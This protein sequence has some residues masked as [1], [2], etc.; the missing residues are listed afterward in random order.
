MLYIGLHSEPAL[1]QAQ[2]KTVV[3][4]IDNATTLKPQHTWETDISP[5]VAAAQAGN[6][7]IR[8]AADK[9]ALEALQAQQVAEATRQVAAQVTHRTQAVSGSCGDP[10]SCIYFRESGNNPTKWNTSGCVGLGQ[11]CPA[12]KLMAIC[13][14]LDYA[15]EDAWFTNYMLGRYGSWEAAWVFWQRTD[16]R[17]YCGN[18]W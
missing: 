15:C 10:K 16:C 1:G 8:D 7:T 3:Q 11:A 2:A 12:S 4:Q 9:A 14:T 13:P 18:W 6:K 17:P 5:R